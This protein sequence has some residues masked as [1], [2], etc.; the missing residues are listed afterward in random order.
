MTFLCQLIFNFKIKDDF[1]ILD[2]LE[3]LFHGKVDNRAFLPVA[4]KRQGS[5]RSTLHV[6]KVLVPK[7]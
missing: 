6:K 5:F 3:R 4:W 2:L 7:F 1:D